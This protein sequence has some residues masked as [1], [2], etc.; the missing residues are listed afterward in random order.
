MPNLLAHSLI[1]KRLYN[2]ADDKSLRNHQNAF[3]H[4]NLEFLTWGSLG[5]D[6]LFYMGIRPFHGLHLITALKKLGNQIHKTDGKKY[7]RYLV[8][9]VY[10][11]DNDKEKK[12]FEAFV[13]G[14]FAHYV[15]D[16]EAHPYILYESG[17]DNNGHITGH[18]HFD[19]AFF[20]THLD[21]ALAKKAGMNRFLSHPEETIPLIQSHLEFIDIYF[22]PVLKKTFDMRKLPKHMYSNA[23]Y[24]TRHFI[25]SMNRHGKIKRAFLGK[26]NGLSA[27]Y[28]PEEPDFRV[29]NE[30]RTVWKDPCTGEECNSSFLELHNKAY[31]IVY[32]CYKDILRNGFNYDVFKNYLDGKNYYGAELNAV[33]KYKAR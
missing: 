9:Q 8:E 10:T 32:Q 30:E 13:F 4:G 12:R 22:V 3:L 33:R 1:V 2:E 20:E 28:Q 7:F 14:Q 17:F 15:L 5:P 21:C 31:R 19:H 25:E 24:N 23:I 6:P 18:Y 27:M 26:C 16:R 11:I 29:L